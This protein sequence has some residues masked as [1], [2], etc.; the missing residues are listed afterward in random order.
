MKERAG[1]GSLPK[2]N[3]GVFASP[4][5]TPLN[6]S[7]FTGK[8]KMPAP[9]L[10]EYPRKSIWQSSSGLYAH[11]G[12]DITH[13]LP[14]EIFLEIF[15]FL[16]VATLLAL[17]RTSRCFRYLLPR[18][19]I[20][21]L[22]YAQEDPVPKPYESS[23]GRYLACFSCLKIRSAYYD[24]R[25]CVVQSTAFGPHGSCRGKRRCLICAIPI[26]SRSKLA[27]NLEKDD[28]ANSESSTR[29]LSCGRTIEIEDGAGGLEEMGLLEGE[30]NEEER[31]VIV[32]PRKPSNDCRGLG[33]GSE[34]TS[35]A[36]SQSTLDGDPDRRL[37][38]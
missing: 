33:G 12:S 29:D 8:V 28:K 2:Y 23:R 5:P 32:V 9:E 11:R 16:D 25:P 31:E 26:G 13:T 37:I 18:D 1:T 21:D 36:D 19:Q 17:N 38:P 27:G 24:F 15:R 34:S 20:L 3:H 14:T 10:V 6:A 4:T 35:V 30:R 7:P 22:L